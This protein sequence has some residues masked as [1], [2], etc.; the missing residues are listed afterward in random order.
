MKKLWILLIMISALILF[1]ACESEIAAPGIIYLESILPESAAVGNSVTLT[2]TGFGIEQMENRVLFGDTA[3]A[4]YLLWSDSVIVVTVPDLADTVNITVEIGGIASNAMTFSLS[5]VEEPAV[6]SLLSVYPSSGLAGDTVTLSGEG[7]GDSIGISKVYFGKTPAKEYKLWSNNTIVA[8]IPDDAQN[9]KLHVYVNATDSNQLDF[10]VL[11]DI[12][13]ILPDEA[14][15]GDVI[16]IIGTGF[17]DIQKTVFIGDTAVKDYYS[18]TN[19]VIV[20]RIPEQAS[21]GSNPVYVQLEDAVSAPVILNVLWDRIT[22]SD[23]LNNNNVYGVFVDEDDLWVSTWGGGINRSSDNGQTWLAY[24]T[25]NGLP[26][27]YIR[28]VE[29]KND[30]IWAGTNVGLSKSTDDGSSWTTYTTTNGLGNNYILSITVDQTSGRVWAGTNN[31]GISKTEDDGTTWTTYTTAEGLPGNY[32]YEIYIENDSTVWAATNGGVSFSEDAGSTWTNFT[33]AQG[34]SGNSCQT[35]YADGNTIWV[36]T[37]DRLNKSTNGGLTWTRYSTLDG[38]GGNYC[39]NLEVVDD[40]LWVATNGYGLS[41][42]KDGG[43]TWENFITTDGLTS[44]TVRDISVY[45]QEIVVA[46]SS[47]VS[48][49]RR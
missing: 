25:A 47:G 46:T 12:G 42:T 6:Y 14:E 9:G 23:G 49:A 32:I 34:L 1:S 37:T 8:V 10:G 28:Q 33:T 35:V 15:Y 39:L 19:K 3:A 26:S 30:D 31:G 16:S 4:S 11:P 18:W 41:L 38:L 36:G 43:S 5:N 20:C 40:S 27:N 48:R 24:N 21:V 45:S 29:L 22:T 44:N 7:F 13:S 17:G 2:G